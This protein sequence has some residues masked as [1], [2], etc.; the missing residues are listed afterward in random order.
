MYSHTIRLILNELDL[1][2]NLQLYC[3]SLT[4]STQTFKIL[5][6]QSDLG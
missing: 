2:Y 4:E 3:Q 6:E 5:M 1:S